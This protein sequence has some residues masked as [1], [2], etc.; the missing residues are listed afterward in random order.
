MPS[1]AVNNQA[2]SQIQFNSVTLQGTHKNSDVEWASTT[3]KTD[4][5]LVP[6]ITSSNSYENSCYLHCTDE[7]TEAKEIKQITQ[8]H[9]E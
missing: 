9:N 4:A 5:F 7:E 2:N 3:S 8:A 1:M 6:Y